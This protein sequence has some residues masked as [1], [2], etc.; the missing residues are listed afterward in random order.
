MATEIKEMP[1]HGHRVYPW[2]KW[3]NGKPW[4][5]KHGKDFTVLPAVFRRQVGNQ[6]RR[7]NMQVIT[8]IKGNSVLFQFSTQTA[9]KPKQS[10]KKK[11]I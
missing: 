10:R 5:A 6:A 9:A 7:R 4:S 3:T 2:E 1:Q 11:G 8:R